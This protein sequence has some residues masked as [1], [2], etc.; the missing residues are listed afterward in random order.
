LLVL[1]IFL[2]NFYVAE[3]HVVQYYFQPEL[4]HPIFRILSQLDLSRFC[5]KKELA[6][7][8]KKRTN[9]DWNFRKLFVGGYGDFCYFHKSLEL[10]AS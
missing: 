2:F 3:G 7:K 9:Y 1:G 10:H 4:V 5:K 8:G 6:K